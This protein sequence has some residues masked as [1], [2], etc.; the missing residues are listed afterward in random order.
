MEARVAAAN[1]RIFFLIIFISYKKSALAS[2][3][4][5]TG[6]DMVSQNAKKSIYQLLNYRFKF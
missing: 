2:I 5:F 1:E 3:I 4:V 6:L